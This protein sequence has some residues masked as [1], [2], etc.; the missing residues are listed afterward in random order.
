MFEPLLSCLKKLSV[1]EGSVLWRQGDEP[2]A[3]YMLES[4]VLRA[5]YQFS[6]NAEVIEESMVGGTVAGELTAL[7]G[8]PRNATV[9]V[10]EA[11]VLW[12]L[13]VTD[14]KK[15]EDTHS[16]LARVFHTLVLRGEFYFSLMTQ[17]KC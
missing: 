5:S 3:L 17:T 14:L 10:E 7:S 12:R 2:D 6:D 1:P 16:Q 11:A 15:L 9:V 8:L 13:E 4:G